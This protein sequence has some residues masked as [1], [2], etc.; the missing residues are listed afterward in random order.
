MIRD[1]VTRAQDL[2]RPIPLTGTP[3]EKGVSRMNL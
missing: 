3:A 2:N 1:S